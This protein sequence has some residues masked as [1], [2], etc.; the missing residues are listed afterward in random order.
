MDINIY[1]DAKELANNIVRVVKQKKEVA[2]IAHYEIIAELFKELLITDND[3]MIGD[4]NINDTYYNS[5]DKEYL[6]AVCAEDK[7]ICIEP[8]FRENTGYFY[9]N[10][11]YTYI[12]SDACCSILKN[13]ET[14]ETHEFSYEWEMDEKMDMCEE[15]INLSHDENDN[16]HGFTQSFS[17][18]NSYSSYSFYSD[19]V[20]I[21]K[22]QLLKIT[23]K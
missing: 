5:Y 11:D 18:G 14:E 15:Y 8:A 4:V 3:I 6:L 22:E 9:V 20:E 23:G 17:D 13:I 10:G 2:V 19:D 1:R 21:V 16:I 12:H 7:N